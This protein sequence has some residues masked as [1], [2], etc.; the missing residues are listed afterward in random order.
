M[1]ILIDGARGMLGNDL[2]PR[3]AER[4]E[5]VAWD[6]QELDITN[7]GAVMTAIAAE[8]PDV[9]IHCAAFTNVDGCER[10]C[11]Q[12]YKVNAFG[13]W[14]VAA[15]CNKID[16]AMVYVSTDFVF[17]GEKGEPY[18]E[19]DTPNPLGA[20]GRSKLA[21]EMIV[22]DLLERHYIARTAWLFGVN[23]KNFVKTILRAAENGGPLRVVADQVGCPTH[24]VDLA[25]TLVDLI[26]S[27]LYG[28]YHIT[29]SGSCSWAEFATEIIRQAGLSTE[30]IPIAAAEWDSPTRRPKDSR[31]RHLALEMQGRDRLK[32]WQEAVT[33]YLRLRHTQ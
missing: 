1:K 17:D 9:V 31:L 13:T 8:H 19:F 22:R 7:T 2:C 30:V 23:G 24:T 3:L 27:P 28:T 14:N 32:S 15:A 12:A 26:E 16:A 29:N 18:D 25:D 33:E 6:L 10:D 5:I 11:L 4:H 20:Y 21:G